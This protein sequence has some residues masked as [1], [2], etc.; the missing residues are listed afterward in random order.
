[1]K[2]RS[3]YTFVLSEH[4]IL[5]G[6]PVVEVLLDGGLIGT[7]HAMDDDDGNPVIKVLSHVLMD[8]VIDAMLPPPAVLIKLEKFK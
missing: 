6:V 3:H 4:T 2:D 8:V 7:I 1:M 5:P